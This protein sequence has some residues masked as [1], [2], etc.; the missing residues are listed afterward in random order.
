MS[1]QHIFDELVVRYMAVLNPTELKLAIA[2]WTTIQ[3]RGGAVEL[4]LPDLAR[5]AGLSVRTVQKYRSTLVQKGALQ[6]LSSR[7]ERSRYALPAGVLIKSGPTDGPGAKA[8]KPDVDE[9]IAKLF[10]ELAGSADPHV[11]SEAE[12]LTG[13]K[14][15][16]FRCLGV[17][18]DHHRRPTAANVLATISRLS[19]GLGAARRH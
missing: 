10:C 11:V 8:D 19:Y 15:E 18:R 17:I 3:D 1:R 16:L 13:G 12:R 2:L 7:R 5:Q 9:Q 6:L 4:T 14:A